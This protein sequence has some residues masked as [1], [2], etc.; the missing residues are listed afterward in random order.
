MDQL[1]H[2]Q[3]RQ[4]VTRDARRKAK[5]RAGYAKKARR[6]GDYVPLG[7]RFTAALEAH[8]RDRT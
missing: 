6:T 1:T 7:K 8:F 2:K 4:Q 5:A 3:A